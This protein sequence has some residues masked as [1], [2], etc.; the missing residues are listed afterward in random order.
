MKL[1]SVRPY[2]EPDPDGVYTITSPDVPG[3]VTEGRTPDEIL[4]NVREALGTLFPF[5]L[6]GP[7]IRNTCSRR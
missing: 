2:L 1:Y 6:L 7:T 4:H 3:L 5:P